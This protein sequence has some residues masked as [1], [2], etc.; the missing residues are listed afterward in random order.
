MIIK[1]IR[2][3]LPVAAALLATAAN[4]GITYN[5][6]VSPIRQFGSGTLVVNYSI[7]TDGTLGTVF[8]TQF[9]SWSVDFVY[10]GNTETINGAGDPLG[11]QFGSVFTTATELSM[12]FTRSSQNQFGLGVSEVGSQIAFSG[13][14]NEILGTGNNP[15]ISVFYLQGGNFLFAGY[16]EPGPGF[17]V[18]GTAA[19][20][21]EPASWAMLIAGFGL[22]GAAMRRRARVAATA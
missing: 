9:Q 20:V 18:I 1:S 22:T 13:L 12:D 14:G 17:H 7:T 8:S 21:P 2:F 19:A 3:A 11:Y 16:V 6:T 5:G 4:A 15:D 10:N